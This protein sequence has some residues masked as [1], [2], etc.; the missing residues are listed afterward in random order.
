MFPIVDIPETIQAGLAPYR[1]LFCRAEGFDGVVEFDPV[2]RKQLAN[3]RVAVR[4]DAT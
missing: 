3:E 4:V 1:A 2:R